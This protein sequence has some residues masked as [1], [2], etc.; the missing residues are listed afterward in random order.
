MPNYQP[1]EQPDGSLRL[2]A[3]AD[4]QEMRRWANG[5]MKKGV[6][7]AHSL[8]RAIEFARD[9]NRIE[10]PLSKAERWCLAR[11]AFQDSVRQAEAMR[12]D[13][14]IG[15]TREGA[16]SF[17]NQFPDLILGALDT[18]HGQ[19][20]ARIRSTKSGARHLGYARKA[21]AEL[22]RIRRFALPSPVAERYQEITNHWVMQEE[23]SRKYER[24]KAAPKP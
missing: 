9:A 11:D 24:K 17:A 20:I 15:L 10:N 2:S 18:L 1:F 14:W 13:A 16:E 12:H 4:P 7:A 5:Y 19:T 3:D 8:V 21:L 6:M 23:I 22:D